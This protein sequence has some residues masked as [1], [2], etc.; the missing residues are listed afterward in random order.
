M[1]PVQRGLVDVALVLPHLRDRWVFPDV[2][3]G[4]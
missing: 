3:L 1:S 2:F 4:I